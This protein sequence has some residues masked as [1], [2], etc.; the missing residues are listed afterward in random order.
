[1]LNKFTIMMKKFFLLFTAVLMTAGVMSA[2]D[3]NKAIEA[4]NNGND[5]FQLGDYALALEQFQ[6]S[7]TIAEGLGEEGAEHAETCKSAICNLH[8]AIA[9]NHYNDKNFTAAI[10][11]F[12]KAKEVAAGFGKTEIIEEA[13]ELAKNTQMN[14][15]NSAAAV[16]KKAKNYAGAIENY[17]KVIEMDPSNGVALYQLGDSYYRMKNYDEAVNY[18]LAAKENG[19]EKNAVKMLSQIYLK[20]AQ[21][22]LKTKQYQDVIDNCT[23][24][25]EYLENGNA[26]KLAASAAQKLGNNEQCIALYEKYLEVSP[27]A[28]DANGV[29]CTIAVLYQQAGNKEKAVEYYEKIAA[30]PQFGATAQEQLKVLK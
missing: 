20:K 18:C 15:Y 3:L 11:A 21:D 14:L 29:I 4:A 16:A 5:A 9:K 28:K 26:Y 13:G 23:K 12:N 2:Q 17:K 1:M 19:Q 27:K 6:N 24:S 22:G 30:D 8:M 10:D 25:N 7:L